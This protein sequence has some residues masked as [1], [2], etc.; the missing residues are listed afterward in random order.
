MKRILGAAR[1]LFSRSAPASDDATQYPGVVGRIHR[2]DLMI[3]GTTPEMLAV[4]ERIGS[5]AYTLLESALAMVGRRPA[6][7]TRVLD[8]GCGYG[9]VLRAIVQHI[10]PR[11][12]D[13]F[14]VD[15]QG[16]AFCA[17][18][19]GVT[20]LGFTRPWDWSSVPFATYDLIW[21][22]SVFTHLGEAF[23]REMLELWCSLLRPGGVLVF[24]THGDEAIRRAES[25][26]FD[27]RYQVAAP[28]VRADYAARGFCFLPYGDADFAILPFSF[29]R[30]AEFGMTWMSEDYIA[31][32]VDAVG[33][34]DLRLVSFVPQAWEGVQDAAIVQRTTNPSQST[35]A[36]ASQH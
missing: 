27:T 10:E 5:S 25:G 8:F 19:F 29:E 23:T 2:S 9:R 17:R 22:G 6:D 21:A 4:Y 3:G 11:R 13:V 36:A 24:T 35:D 33:K 16:V 7:V 34:G 28:R 18:E 12:V 14:D 32:L 20:G 26:F 1:R 15:Q 31:K 30:R